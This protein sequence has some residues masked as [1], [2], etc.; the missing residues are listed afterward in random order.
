MIRATI[1]VPRLLAASEPEGDEEEPTRSGSRG[2]VVSGKQGGERRAKRRPAGPRHLFSAWE[3]VAFRLCTAKRVA[4]LLDF[5]GTLVNLQAR[6]GEVRFGQPGRR[7]LARLARHPRVV[8]VIVSGRALADIRR[9]VGVRG[10]R[11]FGLFGWEHDGATAP[12][13]LLAK[14]RIEKAKMAVRAAIRDF[15]GI[16]IEDKGLSCVVHF[17]S[18]RRATI[19][20]ARNT[21]RRVLR[22]FRSGLR[23]LSGKKTWEILP[24]MIR[25]KGA[26]VSALLA[27]LPQ[28]TLPIYAGDDVADESAFWA[29]RRGITVHVGKS[30]HTRARFRLRNPKEVLQFLRKLEDQL[31]CARPSHFTS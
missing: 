16:W 20:Q 18:A 21:V 19:H 1:V 31:L 11:Y 13:N 5:D 29:L 22:P 17:R 27:R 3:D 26:A 12:A 25:G 9:R 24:S 23:L 6:P 28:S 7:V 15:P 14:R 8:V 2:G 30:R 10:V 4:L